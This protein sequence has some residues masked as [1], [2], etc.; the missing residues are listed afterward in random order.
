MFE[1]RHRGDTQRPSDPAHKK[2]RLQPERDGRA[3][4]RML[5]RSKAL[6][7]PLILEDDGLPAAVTLTIMVMNIRVCPVRKKLPENGENVLS[8]ALFGKAANLKSEKVVKDVNGA[9]VLMPIV[10]LLSECFQ[11]QRAML[12]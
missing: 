3:L 1:L 9:K 4:Q 10:I 8:I 7:T 2:P 5:G 12:K 6:T 11:R